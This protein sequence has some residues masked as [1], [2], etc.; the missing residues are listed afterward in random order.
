LLAHVPGAGERLLCCNAC[1][2]SI[3]RQAR[4]SLGAASSPAP[5][6]TAGPGVGGAAADGRGASAPSRAAAGGSPVCITNLLAAETTC[7]WARLGCPAGAAPHALSPTRARAGQ[8]GGVQ[9]RSHGVDDEPGVARVAPA[10]GALV[11]AAAVPT[12]LLRLQPRVPLALAVA[13][14]PLQRCRS[15]MYRPPPPALSLSTGW[16]SP[17]G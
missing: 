7:Y 9:A 15:A 17:P 10:E 16:P 1:G 2:I 4:R 11:A 12:P 14:S 13:V 6:A 5:A 3:K 8:P